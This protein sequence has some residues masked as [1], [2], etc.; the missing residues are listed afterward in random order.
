MAEAVQ[1]VP[2]LY[3]LVQKHNLEAYWPNF[4]AKGLELEDVS[5]LRIQV[6][7]LRA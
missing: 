1:Q 4:Q 7:R 5:R 2:E 6:N 3:A